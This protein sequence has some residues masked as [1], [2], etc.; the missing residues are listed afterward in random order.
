MERALTPAEVVAL[1]RLQADDL[2]EALEAHG[3]ELG[4]LL[5]SLLSLIARH[6]H[7]AEAAPHDEQLRLDHQTM[8][9][10]EGPLVVVRQA[11][12][13][14]RQRVEHLRRALT[15]LGR[16]PLPLQAG[17]AQSVALFPLEEERRICE[18]AHGV[19]AEAA[20]EPEVEVFE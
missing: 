17:L 14:L 5:D 19:A 6:A 9:R 10:F 1:T 8:L 11:Q 13:R 2:A 7:E 12:D 15:L 18:R 16:A 4:S 20:R 3:T